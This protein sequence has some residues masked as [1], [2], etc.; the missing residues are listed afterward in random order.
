MIAAEFA[1][2]VLQLLASVGE[3]DEVLTNLDLPLYDH[4][5]ELNSSHRVEHLI[6]VKRQIEVA[7]YLVGLAYRG[8]ELQNFVSEFRSYHV[9]RA[10]S[11]DASSDGKMITCQCRGKRP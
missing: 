6:I 4:Q 2:K 11:R 7:E 3:T 8:Q 9:G 5:D 1:D 10:A